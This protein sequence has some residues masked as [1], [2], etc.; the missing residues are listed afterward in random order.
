MFYFLSGLHGEARRAPRSASRSRSRRSPPASARRSC[1]SRRRSTRTCSASKLDEHGSDG[2]ARQHRLDRRPVRRGRAHADRRDARRCCSAA[3]S[4][5]LDGVEYRTDE[6]FG[7]EVPVEVPGVDSSLLDP[8][9]TWRDPEA[10]DARGARAGRDVPRQ[11][12][13]LRGRGRRGRRG[14]RAAALA[15]GTRPVQPGVCERLELVA[16]AADLEA[17]DPDRTTRPR[18]RLRGGE[19]EVDAGGRRLRDRCEPRLRERCSPESSCASST[20][21]SKRPRSVS[22]CSTRRL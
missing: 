10:Y 5:E 16:A 21:S 22:V 20:R 1:R 13:E 11:L 4:G 12:R 14:R 8:R 9:S 2:L 7:F 17:V 3:L 19:R 18:P 15:V 6:L